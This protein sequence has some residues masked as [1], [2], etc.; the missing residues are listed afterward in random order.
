[1]ASGRPILRKEVRLMTVYE[2]LMFAVAFATLI[3]LILKGMQKSKYSTLPRLLALSDFA[4]HC[5]QLYSRGV[6]ASRFLKS[7]L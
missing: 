1:M 6:S 2:A 7:L 5:G 3:V 4:A